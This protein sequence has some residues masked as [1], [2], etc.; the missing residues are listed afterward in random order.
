M[1]SEAIGKKIN[2]RAWRSVARKEQRQ[3][4]EGKY[5]EHSEQKPQNKGVLFQALCN[6]QHVKRGLLERVG[7]TL[8]MGIPGFS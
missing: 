5:W 3:D 4:E 1:V 6:P 2:K 8:S 7:E